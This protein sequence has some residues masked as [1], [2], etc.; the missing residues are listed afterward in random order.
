MTDSVSFPDSEPL[1]ER[2]SRNVSVRRK[3]LRITQARLAEQLSVE[4]ETISRLERGKH[5]P[6]I[7]TLEKI[8]QI[9][10]VSIA[11]LLAEDTV[12]A[13]PSDEALAVTAWLS[14]LSES[15]RQFA[16]KS[17]RQLCDHLGSNGRLGDAG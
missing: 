10:M 1:A 15:D 14:A 12:S 5:L 9:L 7:A 8:A 4:P 16:L 17:L 6:S 13:Q 11:D 3:S 2:L